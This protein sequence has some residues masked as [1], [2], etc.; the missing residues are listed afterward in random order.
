MD[1][2]GNKLLESGYGV[3]AIAILFFKA[4]FAIVNDIREIQQIH[5]ICGNELFVKN[6][7]KQFSVC[8][9]IFT[10]THN[11]SLSAIY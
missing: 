6:L 7:R 9:L 1:I 4:L 8:N 5:I 11:C 3:F 10:I 2:F